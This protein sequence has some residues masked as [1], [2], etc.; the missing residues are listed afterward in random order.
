MRRAVR[1]SGGI[2]C[3]E[4]RSVA[5]IRGMAKETLKEIGRKIMMGKFD[6]STISLPAQCALRL[7]FL[8]CCDS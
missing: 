3:S 7:F 8:S 5:Q 2:Y 4:E 6:L 1:P